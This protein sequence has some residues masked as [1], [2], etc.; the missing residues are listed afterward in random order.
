MAGI[1]AEMKFDVHAIDYAG[2][3]IAEYPVGSG[4]RYRIY[5]TYDPTKDE[6]IELTLSD[7]PAAQDAPEEAEGGDDDG[8]I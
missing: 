5:R 3:M 4:K 2:Q 1:A 8:T 6:L 7:T